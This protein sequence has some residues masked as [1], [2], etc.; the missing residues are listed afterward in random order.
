MSVSLALF[1][2]Y[3]GSYLFDRYLS[4][5]TRNSNSICRV[6]ILAQTVFLLCSQ[7]AIELPHGLHSPHPKPQ[8]GH[9]I[10]QLYGREVKIHRGLPD[11]AH[12]FIF[13]FFNPWPGSCQPICGI[14]ITNE[15]F[16]S[17]KAALVCSSRASGKNCRHLGCRNVMRRRGCAV[18]K[19]GIT[20]KIL[21]N[22][23]V[24]SCNWKYCLHGSHIW[25]T[26]I[27]LPWNWFIYIH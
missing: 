6:V 1:R 11:Q 4:L 2:C 23:H 3:G 22:D 18:Q 27:T 20:L 25:I 16:S 10:L 13:F 5:H 21:F 9:L 15:S 7:R 12:F 14:L 8:Q 17:A 24:F 19:K 26:S